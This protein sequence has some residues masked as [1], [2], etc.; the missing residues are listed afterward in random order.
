M[1][2]YSLEHFWVESAGDVATVGITAYA[3]EMLGGIRFLSLCA[4]GEHLEAGMP[5]GSLETKKLAMEIVSPVGGEILDVKNM[6]ELTSADP[7]GEGWLYKAKL[8]SSLDDL[9]DKA[10]YDRRNR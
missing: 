3:V 6:P 8:T 10:E 1:K 4:P 5:A 7:E 9:A 2:L